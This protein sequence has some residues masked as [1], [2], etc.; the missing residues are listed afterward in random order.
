MYVLICI[1]LF[2]HLFILVRI[3]LHTHTH[4]VHKLSRKWLASDLHKRLWAV[5]ILQCLKNLGTLMHPV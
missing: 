1:D 4:C 2:M 5:S 3:Y